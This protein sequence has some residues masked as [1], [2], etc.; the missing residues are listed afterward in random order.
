MLEVRRFFRQ[1]LT[2]DEG[3]VIVGFC[4]FGTKSSPIKHDD[5]T[6]TETL[7]PGCFRNIK[8]GDTIL[9]LLNHD[10]SMIL[11][12][13]KDNTLQI[14]QNDAGVSFRLR[15]PDNDLGRDV[16]EGIK[17]RA[18]TGV[19]PSFSVNSDEWFDNNQ[20]RV[21]KD[22]TLFELSLV[23]CAAYAGSCA[24]IQSERRNY[25]EQEP[26]LK[27]LR[28]GIVYHDGMIIRHIAPERKP[29]ITK[30]E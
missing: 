23:S 8:N 20:F 17:S 9:A 4:S 22:A 2:V 16:I 29:S 1:H 19:S 28:S 27:P 3:N 18:I 6:F 21:I 5:R 25:A 14:T 30:G 7:A 24:S 26:E 10:S 13:T 11:G 15:L 12:S